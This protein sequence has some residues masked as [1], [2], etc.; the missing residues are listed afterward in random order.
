VSLRNRSLR[1]GNLSLS[2]ALYL[3]AE[4]ALAVVALPVALVP[5][6]ATLRLDV[7]TAAAR[8]RRR[9]WCA[10]SSGAAPPWETVTTLI[11]HRGLPTGAP[12]MSSGSARTSDV[13]K[14]NLAATRQEPLNKFD[15]GHGGVARK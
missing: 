10:P 8:G 4:W 14:Q 6:S 13:L 3:G 1:Q 11:L 7:L 9:N 12:A 15:E 2:E 5:D